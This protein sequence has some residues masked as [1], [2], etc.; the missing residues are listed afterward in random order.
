[1]SLPPSKLSAINRARYTAEIARLSRRVGVL[2]DA[3]HA[4][5]KVFEILT[6]FEPGELSEV[7]VI[8]RKSA[9][10]ISKALE[11]IRSESP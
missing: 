9:E 3:L 2:E 5:I 11:A 10:N 4:S 1:M 6:S 8:A 7:K